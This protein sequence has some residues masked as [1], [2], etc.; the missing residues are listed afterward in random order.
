FQGYS[1]QTGISGA[2]FWPFQSTRPTDIVSYKV[3]DYYE[4]Y[5]FIENKLVAGVFERRNNTHNSQSNGVSRNFSYGMFVSESSQFNTFFNATTVPTTH[6][7]DGVTEETKLRY[8][9]L[10]ATANDG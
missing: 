10:G 8:K 7:R 6:W 9:T 5:I 1:P 2:Y 4:R 3:G